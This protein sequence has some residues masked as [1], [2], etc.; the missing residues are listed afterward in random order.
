VDLPDWFEE[1]WGELRFQ[2]LARRETGDGYQRLFHLVMR[3]VAGDDFLEVRPVGKHGDFACD[4]WSMRSRTCYA[5]YAPFSRK[6][7]GQVRRKVARDL[8]GAVQAWPEMREWRPVHNDYAGLSALVASAVVSLKE[9]MDGRPQSVTILPPW[10]PKDLWGLLREAPAGARAS[11][12]G[13]HVWRTDHDQLATFARVNN[14]PVSISAR[15]SVRQL[16]DG[17]ATGGV[18]DPLAAT[19]FGA[20]LAAFLLGDEP[21]F[22]KQAAKLDQRCRDDPFEAMLTSIVFAVKAM[23]LWE[24]A[25]GETPEQWAEILAAYGVTVPYAAQIVTSARLGTG[26][27]ENVPGH[28]DD[29]RKVT[30]NLGLVTAETLQ[31]AAQHRSAS[32]VSVLQDLLIDVQREPGAA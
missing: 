24:A 5:V 18:V 17:F 27:G 16:L 10:G 2:D 29:H 21:E 20:T 22:K 32:L 7:P 28:P 15:R 12:L 31:L 26:T 19:A 4:G 9:D 30:M 3:A 11:I 1:L 8:Q 25:T 23:Q 14:D 13:S 6:T